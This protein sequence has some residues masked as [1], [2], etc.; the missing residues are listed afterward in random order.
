MISRKL[1]LVFALTAALASVAGPSVVVAAAQAA[2]PD[3]KAELPAFP[4]AE[5]FGRLA[6]GGRGGDVY[7]VTN[8]NDRGPGSLREG[9]TSAKG[10]RTIVFEVG[11]EIR[12]QGANL[13]GH[14]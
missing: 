1:S 5:G 14:V 11:G 12:L 8:L 13:R 2:G 6:R 10:P 3:S 4:G 9:I 7:H